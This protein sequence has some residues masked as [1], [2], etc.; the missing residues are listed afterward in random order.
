VRRNGA[1][2]AVTWRDVT[3]LA[4]RYAALT[5]RGRQVLQQV[6]E[7]RRSAEIAVRLSISV[8]T[9]ELHRTNLMRKLRVRTQT[10]LVRYA[11]QR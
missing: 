10:E 7:G 3:E 2:E 5:S 11:L 1:W 8:R 4:D 6:A 9:V